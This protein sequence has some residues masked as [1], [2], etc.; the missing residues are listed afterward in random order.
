MPACAPRNSARRGPC[1]RGWMRWRESVRGFARR[2]WLPSSALEIRGGS[3]KAEKWPDE[4]G[5]TRD[6]PVS[7]HDVKKRWIIS[8][9][10]VPRL[11]NRCQFHVDTPLR[12]QISH[13]ATWHFIVYSR[14]VCPVNER[15]SPY[16][17]KALV[18]YS[19]I[20]RSQGE[21]PEWGA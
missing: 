1:P 10:Y 21:R 3:G 2:S 8:I 15:A 9:G 20:S 11:K 17:T 4:T 5:N 13:L 19:S 12:S 14:P 18:G 7:S 6:D 16:P